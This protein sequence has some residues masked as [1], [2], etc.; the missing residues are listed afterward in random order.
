V[1][2]KAHPDQSVQ[3]DLTNT[4]GAPVPATALDD[5][6]QAMYLIQ[7]WNGNSHGA[8]YLRLYTINGSVAVPVGFVS[9]SNPW[10]DAGTTDDSDFAPQAGT[11]TKIDAGD[12]RLL[13]AYF[14]NGA[15]WTV[16]T[17]FLPASA[18]TRSAVQWWEI[19]PSAAV[20]QNGLID[21]PQSVF[22]YAYPS[23][24]VNRQSDVL[25]AG[26]R[27]SA[28]T[29]PSAFFTF[30]AAGDAPNATA[31]PLIFKEGESSYAKINNTSNRWGDYSTAAV[32][33]SNDTDFW[34]IQE[35]AARPNAGTDRWGTWWV[36]VQLGEPQI[37][38][39]RRAARH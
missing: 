35:Y 2:D 20:Q 26:T 33:P 31:T 19:A 8:G 38:P 9:T 15:V 18:P 3:I 17:I 16:H 24:A 11:P 1:I 12:D 22:F 25:I 37:A 5:S 39:K 21:D 23:I 34:A 29:L 30:R 32:D 36:H 14:R 6:G 7:A 10:A 13:A 4:G 27:F 28:T